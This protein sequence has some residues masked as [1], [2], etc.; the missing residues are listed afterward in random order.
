MENDEDAPQ[1]V[2]FPVKNY[3]KEFATTDASVI[4]RIYAQFH[5]ELFYSIRIGKLGFSG[6]VM[7][8]AYQYYAGEVTNEQRFITRAFQWLFSAWHDPLLRNADFSIKPLRYI[9]AE[10][11]Q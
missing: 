10:G 5:Q 2:P 1:V 7:Q 4:E 9:N 11:N 3:D 6:Q 8:D